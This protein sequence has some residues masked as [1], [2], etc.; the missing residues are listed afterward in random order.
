MGDPTFRRETSRSLEAYVRYSGDGLSLSVTGYHTRFGRFIAALPTGDEQEDLP[1]FA[2]RQLPARFTGFEAEASWV[3]ARWDGG[4]LTL[5]AA[6]DYTHARL[7]GV[8]PVPRIPALRLRGG[9]EAKFGAMHLRGEVEWNDRQDRVA[10][11]ENPVAS[12]TLVNLSADW[13]PLGEDGPLT[14]I[15]A[16]NNLFDVVGRRAASF[17]R[18][19]VP[20]SGRDVR[21]TAKISF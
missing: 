18:D 11:F 5:D 7:K 3:A 6:A 17:T 8:G 20:L 2:Y 4:D 14:L 12:F 1:V 13:H 9:A 15:L 19:F 16:A 10:T 21:L